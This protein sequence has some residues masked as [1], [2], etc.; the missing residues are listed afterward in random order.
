MHPNTELGEVKLKVSNIERSTKFY[1]EVVGLKILKQAGNTAQFTADGHTALLVIEEI[2]NAVIVPP[3]STKGLYHFAIL[4]PN[5]KELGFSLRNLIRHGIRIGQADHLVSEALYISDPDHNG[6]EIYADRPRE[7][8]KRDAQG[9]YRMA[10]DPIDWEGLLEEAG[11]QPWSGL[12]SET[13]MGHV[14]FHVGDLQTTKRFYC[15][16]LS[17]DVTVSMMNMGALF[18]S[19]GGYH[20]HLGL[21]VWAGVGAPAAPSNGTGLAYYTIVLPNQSELEHTLEQLRK[22]EVSLK[23][24]DG[25]WFAKDPSGI[26]IRFIA[27]AEA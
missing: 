19:A 18:V 16:I 1:E 26:G 7:S 25:S 14:H 17:F 6:I 4:V 27:K 24:Q 5:R 13:I 11:E 12:P 20:H 3:R 21:N 9:N 23:E 15:D 10:T 22:A 8:W 2:P